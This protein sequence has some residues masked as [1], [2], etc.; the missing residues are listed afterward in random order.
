[1]AAFKNELLKDF[2]NL[3]KRKTSHKYPIKIDFIML[4]WQTI[5]VLYSQKK[6][7]SGP[8]LI[9]AK[10]D[11]KFLENMHC[12]RQIVSRCTLCGVFRYV[13]IRGTER[14]ENAYGTFTNVRSQERCTVVT[15]NDPVRLQ[16]YVFTQITGTY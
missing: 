10:I 8:V 1:L 11:P 9:C 16:M 15:L 2:Q 13:L 7:T 4:F 12:C 6:T 5:P 3:L 14:V